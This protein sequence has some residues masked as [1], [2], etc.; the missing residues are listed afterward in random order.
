MKIT[1][2]HRVYI[3][4]LEHTVVLLVEVFT[5]NGPRKKHA[6][7]A[8]TPPVP[9]YFKGLPDEDEDEDDDDDDDRERDEDPEEWQDS[10]EEEEHDEKK[11]GNASLRDITFVSGILM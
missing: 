8:H 10:D 6:A 7:L 11:K 5:L 1:S 9:S 3:N 4:Q 2:I